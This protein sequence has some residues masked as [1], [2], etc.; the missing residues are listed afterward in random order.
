MSRLM[1]GHRIAAIVV[2]IA[3][4]AW[5]ATGKFSSV[6]SDRVL[7]AQPAAAEQPAAAAE[8]PANDT[9][10]ETAGDAAAAQPLLPTV[11]AMVP[12][13]AEHSRAIRISGETQADKSVMLAARASGVI[14]QLDVA[15][16]QRIEAGAEVLVLEGPELEAAVT[17]A[18]AA[19]AQASQQLDA[20]EKLAQTGNMAELNLLAV[21]TAKAAAEAQLSQAQQAADR[22]ILRAPFSGVIDSVPVEK[23]QWLQS[24]ASVA[25]LLSLD[26]IVVRAEL[27][28]LDVGEIGVGS[29]AEV[30]LVDGRKFEGKVRYVSKLA[31][32]ITR[33][34][35]VEVALANPAGQ[36]P[37]GMTAQITLY[38]PPVRAVTVPRSVITLSENGDLGLRTVDAGNIT[39][40]TPVTLVDDTPDGLVLAGVPAGVKIIVSG[41]DLVKDGQKVDV[42][43]PPEGGPTL[44]GAAGAKP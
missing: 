9:A 13:F 44:E 21:R 17:N 34:F 37:A 8:A 39:H 26:P 35:P 24:G 41:Q 11:A 31:S 33:T 2:L 32:K 15:E 12:A 3:A 28:E 25:E 5:V 29:K 38:A 18:R 14:A 7:A 16:G 27:N 23:G 22:L 43:P 4:A 42:V 6:G 1:P 10:G 36:I 30:T 20:D 40:F 19:L